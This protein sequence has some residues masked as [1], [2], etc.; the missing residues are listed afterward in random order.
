L[1]QRSTTSSSSSSARSPVTGA[2]ACVSGDVTVTD[3]SFERLPAVSTA[4]TR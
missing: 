4:A 3:A 2:G 1:V